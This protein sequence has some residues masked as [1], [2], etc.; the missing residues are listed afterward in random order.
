MEAYGP[1]RERVYEL[2]GHAG[3][4]LEAL[5]LDCAP[6]LVLTRQ[7]APSFLTES[8]DRNTST[9]CFR[10]VPQGRDPR[11]G[12]SPSTARLPHSR[13]KLTTLPLLPPQISKLRYL[14]PS[15][16]FRKG[17]QYCNVLYETLTELPHALL[18]VTFQDYVQ[19]NFFSP[20]NMTSSTL[21]VAKAQALP[22]GQLASGYLRSGRNLA[23]GKEGKRVAIEPYFIPEG[24]DEIWRGAGGVLTSARDLVSALS[25]NRRSTSEE[26]L[27][28][29]S[30]ADDVACDAIEQG[31]ASIHKRDCRT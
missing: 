16:E 2:G 5:I 24:E 29:D 4:F 20:L 15:T 30:C 8:Q 17:W 14:R 26:V 23:L 9:R 6:E 13:P 21:S 28:S 27:T 19:E 7:K 1:H 11:D 25:S 10:T 3:A 18:N 22:N 12:Q 31:Q